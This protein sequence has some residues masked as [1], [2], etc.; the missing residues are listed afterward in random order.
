MEKSISDSIL[1]SNSSRQIWIDLEQRFGQSNGTKFF[2]IKRDLYS[3]TQ[4]NRDIASYFTEIKKLW[5]EHESM[6][7]TPTCSCGTTCATYVDV[8][9]MRESEK[10]IQLLVGLNDVYKTVRGNILMS[11]ALP[12]VSEAYYMLLPEEHQREM[13]SGA[14]IIPHSAALHTNTF[15]GFGQDP[16]AMMGNHNGYGGK[17]ATY[18]QEMEIEIL[19][20]TL[21]MGLITVTIFLEIMDTTTG[22][23]GLENLCSVSIVRCQDTQSKNATKFMGTSQVTNCMEE[24]ELQSLQ[25]KTKRMVLG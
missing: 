18:G 7:S 25:L 16:S 3:I 12:T 15:N 23:M 2:Q 5:D 6:L 22:I 14:H 10:L 13:S 24:R 19:E 9:K 20:T 17:N 21:V 4:G 1:F 8:H 11:K